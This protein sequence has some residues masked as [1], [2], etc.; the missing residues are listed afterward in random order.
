MEKILKAAGFFTQGACCF[1]LQSTLYKWNTAKGY[2]E[3]QK[4]GTHCFDVTIQ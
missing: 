2:A 1:F 4:N 3:P